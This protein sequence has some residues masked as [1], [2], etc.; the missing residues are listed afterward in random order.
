MS[1]MAERIAA[2]RDP[3]RLGPHGPGQWRLHHADRDSTAS[4]RLVSP[5]GREIARV[6][7]PH[8]A[9]RL[10]QLLNGDQP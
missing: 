6:Y 9:A 7:S 5:E 3:R 8:D 1:K 2:A 10:L 4:V